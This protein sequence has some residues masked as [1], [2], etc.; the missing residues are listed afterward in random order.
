MDYSFFINFFSVGDQEGKKVQVKYL[1]FFKIII[2]IIISKDRFNLFA[3]YAYSGK[4]DNLFFCV[5]FLVTHIGYAI[6]LWQSSKFGPH[7]STF[8]RA[9]RSSQSQT[10]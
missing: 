1:M 3:A 9:N 5:A 2:I 6:N 7:G 10:S 4:R 8:Q